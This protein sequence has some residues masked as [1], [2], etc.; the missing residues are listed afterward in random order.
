MKLVGR[1]RSEPL[2]VSMSMLSPSNNLQNVQAC[3]DV[4][5]ARST[6]D[7]KLHES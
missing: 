7:W 1:C 6:D 2:T 3:D 4:A 5:A